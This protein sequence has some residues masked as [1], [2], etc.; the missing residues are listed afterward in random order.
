[1]R[2]PRKLFEEYKKKFSYLLFLYNGL[3]FKP[4]VKLY[5]YLNSQTPLVPLFFLFTRTTAKN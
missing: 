2:Y 1:M 4:T 3:M 5:S